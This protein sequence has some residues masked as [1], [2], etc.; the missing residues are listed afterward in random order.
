MK[1]VMIQI[2][3]AHDN[4]LEIF[5]VVGSRLQGGESSPEEMREPDVSQVTQP[6]D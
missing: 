3:R 4:E 1:Q 2:G 6:A 5:M